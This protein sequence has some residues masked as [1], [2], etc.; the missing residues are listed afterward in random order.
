MYKRQDLDSYGFRSRAIQ[1][2][3][4]DVSTFT[5]IQRMK[6]KEM[7]GRDDEHEIQ[8]PHDLLGLNK[9]RKRMLDANECTDLPT[10]SSK[11]KRQKVQHI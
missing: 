3:M 10:L 4:A 7:M 8:Y 2:D 9:E 6:Y 11:M 5:F 1:L